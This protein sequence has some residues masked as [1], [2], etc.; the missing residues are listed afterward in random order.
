M[1]AESAGALPSRP[2]TGEVDTTSAAR[3]AI[4]S[5]RWA[6]RGEKINQGLALAPR[7]DYSDLGGFVCFS[8]ATTSPL[9][10]IASSPRSQARPRYA[11]KGWVWRSRAWGRLDEGVQSRTRHRTGATMA[12]R[13]GI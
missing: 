10:R 13:T 3:T 1:T 2:P 6:T 7:S 9:E 5:T 11:C 8:W 4:R 12:T